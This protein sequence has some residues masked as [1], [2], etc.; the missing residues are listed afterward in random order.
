MQHWAD[1]ENRRGSFRSSQGGRRGES[2]QPTLL[3]VSVSPA[4]LKPSEHF[5]PHLVSLVVEPDPGDPGVARTSET[6][7]LLGVT[8]LEHP[9]AA[10]LGSRQV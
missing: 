3:E 6:E 8:P 10:I 7:D 1:K 9:H 5:T 4:V 2:V